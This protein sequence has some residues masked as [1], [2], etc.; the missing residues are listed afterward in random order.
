MTDTQIILI[1]LIWMRHIGNFNNS[2]IIMKEYFWGII[3]TM[4]ALLSLLIQ[5]VKEINANI[6]EKKAKEQEERETLSL[7]LCNQIEYYNGTYRVKFIN[8]SKVVTAYNLHVS[9]RI[10]NKH[11]N[12]TYKL[13]DFSTQ[14]AIYSINQEKD[15]AS[16]E[17]YARINV[18]EIEEKEIMKNAS[19]EIINLR[20]SG[21]LELKKMLV[22]KENYLAIRYNAV[23]SS[24]GKTIEFDKHIYVYEDIVYGKFG[25]GHDFVTPLE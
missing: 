21:K 23:N 25:I 20:K 3:G 1:M 7:K 16:C 14:E 19:Q 22:D 10:K 18:M 13:P 2:R 17:I 11:F 4:A 15:K 12:Y 24:T 9:I 5:A 6:R 8:I